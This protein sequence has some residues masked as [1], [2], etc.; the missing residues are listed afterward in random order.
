MPVD[1]LGTDE[2][3]ESAP[4]RQ[5]EFESQLM[6]G[7]STIAVTSILTYFMTAWP[8]AA[9]PEY[10]TTGL[11]QILLF[12]ALPATVLGV[13]A[14]RRFALAGASGFFGGAMAAAV[15]MHLRFQQTAIGYVA[16]DMPRPDYPILVIQ[17]LP[18]AWFAWSGLVALIFCRRESSDM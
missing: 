17:L 3:L 18:M 14:S 16:R 13:L 4:P 15:F 12:G 10:S 7:C 2:Q 11:L 8:F 1:G 5:R 6:A 9:F